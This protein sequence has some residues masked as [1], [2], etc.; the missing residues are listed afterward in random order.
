[1]ATNGRAHYGAPKILC[2]EADLAV[3]ESR[4]AVLN[5]SGYDATAA[6]SQLADIVLR[7]QKFDLIVLSATSDCDW[8]R[9]FNLADGADVL[10]L[11]GFT[12]PLELLWLVAERLSRLQQRAQPR[13]GVAPV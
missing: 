2:V 5:K 6:A 4:C 9:I 8:H 10:V 7:I 12:M 11:D 3:R 13:Q 1:M